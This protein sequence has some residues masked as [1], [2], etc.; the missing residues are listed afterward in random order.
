M[1]VL[2]ELWP[3][4]TWQA[5]HF[6]VLAHSVYLIEFW[7]HNK[8]VLKC[9]VNVWTHLYCPHEL[10]VT[11]TAATPTAENI[12]RWTKS[13]TTISIFLLFSGHQHAHV[14]SAHQV[15]PHHFPLCSACREWAPQTQV[16]IDDAV[17]QRMST[18]KKNL[19]HLKFLCIFICSFWLKKIAPWANN[20]SSSIRLVYLQNNQC[21][22]FSS[23][24]FYL[25]LFLKKKSGSVNHLYGSGMT[26]LNYASGVIRP[27][28]YSFMLRLQYSLG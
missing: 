4:Y 7:T 28:K 18:I 19:Y 16:E 8:T 27:R 5:F 21:Q 23:S 24:S 17:S 1:Q 13:V 3:L 2:L 22:H 14:L 25:H 9:G 10:C 6:L 20:N 12:D 26:M 15:S 11:A